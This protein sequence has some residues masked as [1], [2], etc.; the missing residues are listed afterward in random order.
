LEEI[1][2]N[3]AE[4]DKASIG[5]FNNLIYL[6]PYLLEKYMAPTAKAIKKTNDL[7]NTLFEEPDVTMIKT[8]FA[9]AS[10]TGTHA[11]DAG[12]SDITELPV[13]DTIAAT[14]KLKNIMKS[15]DT[16]LE[17]YVEQLR[18]AAELP[19]ELTIIAMADEELQQ[20]NQRLN[21]LFT[22]F[23]SQI[24]R[25][26]QTLQKIRSENILLAS[27]NYAQHKQLYRLTDDYTQIQ[28]EKEELTQK[29]H[30]LD[31]TN[32]VAAIQKNL[33]DLKTTLNDKL[34]G[35]VTNSSPQR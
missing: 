18:K 25:D 30:G 34:T 4:E 13:K 2:I 5:F 27:M 32:K 17:K 28:L 19:D 16:A 14:T 7:V 8:L 24:K 10:L 12:S 22:S 15:K 6:P 21:R 35:S 11:H 29:V 3:F 9:E 20:R 26:Y 33:D 1:L 31:I 23:E